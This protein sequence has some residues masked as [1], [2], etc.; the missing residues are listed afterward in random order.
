MKQFCL[1]TPESAG[2]AAETPHYFVAC[3]NNRI[4]GVFDIFKWRSYNN[5][6]Q[7]MPARSW[8]RVKQNFASH[9]ESN[10]K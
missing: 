2:Q 3:L 6:L 9:V 5:V 7:H 8:P 4:C 10:W 1:T